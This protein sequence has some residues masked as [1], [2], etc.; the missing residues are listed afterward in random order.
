MSTFRFGKHKG[1]TLAE[2]AAK[3]PDYLQWLVKQDFFRE[4]DIYEEVKALVATLPEPTPK[5]PTGEQYVN[6]TGDC[7]SVGW[8]KY[9]DR[10]IADLLADTDYCRFLYRQDWF[11]K[12]T[13]LYQ[14]VRA[15]FDQGSSS[16][17]TTFSE[18]VR[19]GKYKDQLSSKLLADT[20]YC[21]FLMKQADFNRNPLYPLVKAALERAG[22]NVTA[23]AVG[24]SSDEETVKFGKYRGQPL[25]RLLQDTGYCSWLLGQAD[26]KTKHAELYAKLSSSTAASSSVQA[27]NSEPAALWAPS[28]S[29][30]AM[31]DWMNDEP[32]YSDDDEQ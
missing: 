9:K 27:A 24:T 25:S 13:E 23:D 28:I 10:S 21:A 2:V 6:V 19:F 8:G 3:Q 5:P 1:S 30:E 17:E 18:P 20:D 12:H 26:F 22:V 15:M 14:R 16:E 4:Y 29:A 7:R 31:S 32:C 11:K